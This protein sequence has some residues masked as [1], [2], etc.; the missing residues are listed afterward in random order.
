MRAVGRRGSADAGTGPSRLRP[1]LRA[2]VLPEGP[3]VLAGAAA[4]RRRGSGGRRRGSL[5]REDPRRPPLLRS[6]HSLCAG[7][8]GKAVLSPHPLF[9][10][11]EVAQRS[12]DT[13]P[14]SPSQG[15]PKPG[16]LPPD[17]G[18]RLAILWAKAL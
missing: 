13:G 16:E 11:E 17:L 6:E 14:R 18:G 3:W 7:T 5:G 1:D 4:R 15:G 2:P 8:P 12:S 9:P 10:G